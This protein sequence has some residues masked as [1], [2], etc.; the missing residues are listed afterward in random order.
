MSGL[1][2]V[3]P[4]P[5]ALWVLLATAVPV[6]LPASSPASALKKQGAGYQSMEGCIRDG[7]LTLSA[8]YSPYS[9]HVIK[10]EVSGKIVRI[11]AR[12]GSI[13]KAGTPLME[14]DSRALRSQLEQLE[15]VLSS[16]GRSEKVLMRDLELNRKKYHR[17]VVLKEKRHV[18]AQ[19]V[20][21]VE[22]ELHG[23]ELALIENRRQQ[24]EVRRNIIEID[25][26]ISKCAPSFSRDFYVAENFK[27]LYET[28]VPGEAISRLLDVSRAKVHLVLSPECFSVVEK[29]LDEGRRLDFEVITEDG[30]SH[31]ARGRVE[32]LKID[33]DNSYL[34]SYGFDLV[35]RPMESILWGQVVKVRLELG[36]K[37]AGQAGRQHAGQPP[38]SR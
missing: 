32:K 1:F 11:N 29:A 34:Y 17:Y 23:S 3:F 35:F 18:E 16:L 2:R 37:K 25:D 27:E 9:V 36:Q 7:T 24:A 4:I 38:A 21:N 12:E 20:E 13:L 10:A 14:I 33:P 26:R 6:L 30:S 31:H 28:V 8:A 15:K 22:R 5:C 19:A